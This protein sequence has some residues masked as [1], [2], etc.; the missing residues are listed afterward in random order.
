[1]WRVTRDAAVRLNWRVLVNK[2]TLLVS[3]TLDAGSINASRQSRLFQ[4]KSAMRV[5]AIAALHR[6]FKHA[7][8][9]RLRELCLCFV[10][11]RHAQ[12]R[13]LFHKHLQRHKIVRVRGERTYRDQ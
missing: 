9:E 2:R 4:L 12:L 10:V 11:T 7:V 8:M 13:F 3:V 6:S 5:V 1:M